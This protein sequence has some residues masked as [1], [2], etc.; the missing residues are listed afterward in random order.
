MFAY[1]AAILILMEAT[2][3]SDY[4]VEKI[5]TGYKFTEGPVWTLSN[6]LLF[7]DIPASKIYELRPEQRVFRDPS[8]N[9]NGLTL[10]NEGRLIACEHSNRRVT[11]TEK[12]GSTTV[13]AHRYQGKWFNSPND[14]VVKSDGSVYFTDPTY[15]GK[16]DEDEMGFQGV[17]RARP[18]GTIDLLVKDFHEPNGLCFSPDEK[19]LYVDDSSD[20]RHIR[21]FNV[22]KDGTLSGG[23][24]FAKCDST[25]G[26]P[27]G[28]KVDVEGTLYV[29]AAG[30][31]WVFDKS[32]KHIETIAVPETPANLAWGDEDGKTLYLTAQT[33][34]YKVRMKVGGRLPGRKK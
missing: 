18:D 2:A 23:R 27:D 16:P 26:V 13:L 28:M 34:I 10:D 33:S 32:G 24:L 11:R 30:G 20:L 19:L 9:S 21:V 22:E 3:L 17:Y 12:D 4:K 25:K 14:V 5:S 6:T 31:V 7:S 8:G 1:A 15:G 29:A